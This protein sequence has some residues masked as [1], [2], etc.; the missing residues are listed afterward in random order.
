MTPVDAEPT[1]EALQPPTG[2]ARVVVRG[3]GLAGA[4]YALS[5]ALT[6]ASYFVLAK[7]AAPEDFG[8]FAAATVVSGL[9]AIVGE[10]GMLAALIHRRDRLEEAFNTA[11]LATLASGAVLTL[12]AL[13]MA[14]VIGLF[15][16]SSDT[17]VVAAAMSGWLFLR[18]AAIV[19]DARLQRE[20]SFFRRVIVDP[21]SSVAFGVAAI[22]AAAA[23]MGVWALVVGTYAAAITQTGTSW[24]LGRWRPRPR[25]A[26]LDMWR[27]LARYGRSVVGAEL[28]RRLAGELPVIALGR[29]SGAGP[30]GQF[31]YATRVAT[32]PAGAIVNV[33]G[34]VLLPALARIAG[35]EERFGP[36]FLRALRWLCAI[37]F[38]AGLI[39]VPLGLP[40]VV[41]VF[42]ERWHDAGYGAM[43]LG[44][45]CATAALDSLASETWKAR[46]RP[47]L[48][49]RMHG[50]SLVLTAIL[51]AA[52]LPFDLVGV[53]LAVSLAGL[54]VAVFAV[55]GAARVAGLPVRALLREIWPPA[56]A[57][58]VMAGAVYPVQSALVHAERHGWLAG[59]ALLALEA[60][61]CLAIY[62]G[63]LSVAAPA[64]VGELRRGLVRL[65]ARRRV[66]TAAGGRMS[67][68]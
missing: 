62:L 29:F 19:P 18:L 12:L 56:L 16:H 23:G 1:G 66:R 21:A 24:L 5:Q 64:T 46:G 35:H 42:G 3:A 15:F 37:A 30:L 68:D 50:L 60:L 57:S 43:A 11:F 22:A 14:P 49:P 55:R 7:L 40:A 28:I 67:A 34:Y 25:L 53:S 41:L 38:P 51:V 27:Q 58:L 8:R 59:L 52:L 10:S 2:L 26:S 6:F 17:G 31:S 45:Y 36:A 13:A 65:H 20:F 4:G 32:R 61:L 9:G 39:F 33:G 54:G 48:L 44:L 63:V 47:D